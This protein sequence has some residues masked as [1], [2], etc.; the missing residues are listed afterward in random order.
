MKAAPQ[1]RVLAKAL[2][3]G[4]LTYKNRSE[5]SAAVGLTYTGW[6]GTHDTN[7][8]WALSSQTFGHLPPQSTICACGRSRTEKSS[9]TDRDHFI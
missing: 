7:E 6:L 5:S 4:R 1:F 2:R 8:P 9:R 3:I